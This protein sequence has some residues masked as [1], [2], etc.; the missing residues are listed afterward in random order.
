MKQTVSLQ[1][2]EVSIE[3]W[4]FYA[5]VVFGKTLL[6][7]FQSY[8]FLNVWI[9]SSMEGGERGIF[10]KVMERKYLFLHKIKIRKIKQN[11]GCPNKE[12]CNLPAHLSDY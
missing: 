8:S 6:S 9:N 12:Q 4:I 7:L 2:V 5:F 11:P 1:V 10:S 3:I